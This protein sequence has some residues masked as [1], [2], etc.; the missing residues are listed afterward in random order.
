VVHKNIAPARGVRHR[1]AGEIAS[2]KI[3][4][5]NEVLGGSW[6]GSGYQQKT[7]GKNKRGYAFEWS[8]GIH[9]SCFVV[10]R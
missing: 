5:N 4:V 1:P 6:L 2:L 10:P 3:A 7:D 8:Q 9:G